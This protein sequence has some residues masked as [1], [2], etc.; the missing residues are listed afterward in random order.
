MPRQSDLRYTFEPS[1]GADFEVIEFTLDESLSKP[2]TLA[3]QLASFDAELDFGT[4]LDKTALLTI[5]RGDTPVRYVHG[6]IS[7]LTQGD[8]GRAVVRS[9]GFVLSAVGDAL[10]RRTYPLLPRATAHMTVSR[11]NIQR[12]LAS[13]AFTRRELGAPPKLTTCV[14]PFTSRSTHHGRAATRAR[15]GNHRAR[16]HGR[17]HPRDTR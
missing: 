14:F 3:L 8:T 9:A 5:W 10:I 7:S 16:R 6:L 12:S 1:G 15:I 2:F 17:N 4:L 13:C 11:C